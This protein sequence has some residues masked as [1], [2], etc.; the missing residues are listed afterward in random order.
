MKR[1]FVFFPAFFLALH[2]V[3]S[4]PAVVEADGPVRTE[5]G[6]AIISPVAGRWVNRQPLVL[7]VPESFEAFYSLSGSDPMDSGFAYDGPVMLE[8]EGEVTLKIALVFPSG[9]AVVYTVGYAVVPAEGEDAVL[10]VNLSRPVV[11]YSAGQRLLIPPG[12]SYR[13]GDSPGFLPGDRELSLEGGAFPRRHLPCEITDGV[14]SW[15]FVISP[16]GIPAAGSPVGSPTGKAD[17]VDSPSVGTDGGELP[18]QISEWGLLTFTQ[19]KLIYTIDDAHWQEAA[20]TVVLDRSVGHTI[21]WQSVAY[22][23]GNPVYSLYLPPKPSASL[24][25]H[26]KE[27]VTIDLGPDFTLRPSGSEWSPQPSLRIDAFYGEELDASFSLDIYYKGQYQGRSDVSLRIDKCPPPAPIVESSSEL[28]YNREDVTVGLRQ[29]GEG[30]LFYS[31]ETLVT[32]AAGFQDL[33]LEFS[34]NEI[35]VQEDFLPYRSGPL[36]LE[37]RDN[38]ARLFL[39]RAFAQDRLGNRSPIASYQA[40]VDPVNYYVAPHDGEPSQPGFRRDGSL[41]RPFVSLQQALKETEGKDFV[42]LHLL[43]MLSLREQVVVPSN[44][45]IYGSGAAAGLNFLPGGGL[46]ARGGQVSIK[47]CVLELQAAASAGERGSPM[48]SVLGG[49]LSLDSCEILGDYAG[50]GTLISATDGSL[51][52][53]DSG[54]T[55]R[56]GRYGALVSA[57]RSTV[58]VSGGR[59]AVVAPTAVVFSLSAGRLTLSGSEC[60]VFGQ[61]G[62]VAELTG[63]GFSLTDNSFHGV[64]EDI[65]VSTA[66]LVPIWS[67]NRSKL[68]ESRGNSIFGF[69]GS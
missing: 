60:K 55:L 32:E 63:V 64:F 66:Q 50:D 3:L 37:S 68:I 42:R 10:D 36:L 41:A 67:D 56:S 18:F 53:L 43:G 38:H 62:R 30:E 31:V 11:G 25:F 26:V 57:L 1:F 7:E 28:F 45:E 39:V 21:Y 13:L 65:T 69:L 17:G 16:D 27:A 54:I 40:I 33:A 59:L 29:V 8:V 49:S 12:F 19:D 22:E 20:G 44:C 47:N 46:V 61:L 23:R 52:I 24:K 51:L 14:D 5:E 15:R 34:G 2:A 9:N 6:F 48:L 4:Q 35:V 58:S